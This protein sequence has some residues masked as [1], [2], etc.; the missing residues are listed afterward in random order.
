MA[1]PDDTH[2]LAREIFISAADLIPDQCAGTLI[3][4]FHYLTNHASDETVRYLAQYINASE[5]IYP[6]TNLHLIYQFVADQ[7]LPDQH[8][9]QEI[10]CDLD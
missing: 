10:L 9:E 4:K 8:S 2:F 3:I 1:H 7:F 5:T 6:G